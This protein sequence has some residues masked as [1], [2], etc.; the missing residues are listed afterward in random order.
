MNN[1]P[2]VVAGIVTVMEG[3]TERAEAV[4]SLVKE[5]TSPSEANITAMKQRLKREHPSDKAKD[6]KTN[7]RLKE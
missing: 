2:Q 4:R 6:Y 1:K 3:D 5:R 7:E